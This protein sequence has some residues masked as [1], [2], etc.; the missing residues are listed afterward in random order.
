MGIVRLNELP[1]GSGSLTSDD[2]FIF[3]DDPSGGG[4]TKK[5]S[6]T[7][8]GNAIGG[9]GSGIN[10]QITTV[11]LHNGGVQTAQVL[12]F[13]D[14][15]YQS[16]ITGP[17]PASGNNAQRIIVQGSRGQGNG[18]G[19]DVYMWG[20]DS[21]ING[22]D[23]K[24]YAG[25]A[26]NAAPN[27]GYG[28]YVNIDGGGGATTGGNVEITAGYSEGGQAGDIYIVGGPTSSGVAG[29]VNIR[30]NN[31]TNNWTFSPNGS[32][33]LP[34]GNLI[35]S[36]AGQGETNI[37]I[38][39]NESPFKI[40]TSASTGAKEWRYD[41]NGNL[42]LPQGSILSETNNTVSLM[43]PTAV[44]GQSLVIRPTIAAWSITSSGYIVYD[45]PITIS[46]NQLGVGNYFGTVNYS[47]TGSGVSPQSLGRALTGNVVFSGTGPETET[48]TWTIPS[49]SNISEFTL[50]LTSVE[51]VDW[52][53]I[54]EHNDPALYYNFEENAMPSGQFVTV[55]NSGISNSEHSHIHL[56]AGDPSTVDIYLGDD[57]QYVKIEKNGGDV[58]IGT[59]NNNNHWTFGTDGRLTLPI[60]GDILDSNGTSVLPS[61]IANSGDN[62]ILTSTGTTTGINAESNATFDGS[63]LSVSGV[64]VATSG[65]FTQR[66]DAPLSYFTLSPAISGTV[67]NWNPGSVSDIIR[68]SGIENARINGL[69]NTYGADA[70]LLYN[71]GTSGNI[72]LTH[73]S[74]TANNQFLVPSLGDYVLGPNGGAALIVRDKVD[75]KWRVT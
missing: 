68:A 28:G 61:T 14:D 58:V 46:V 42:T 44:S 6:L 32:F 26:D 70:M 17:I 51:G 21:D 18:E 41:A 53:D 29:D 30:T 57:D 34:N 59:D 22:G 54:P 50:T 7:E 48:I 75:N 55:T 45:S 66:L 20:G 9:G 1:E 36:Q 73:A 49:N 74:G 5:I 56:I 8:I 71:V 37:Q 40:Y 63:T 23:I 69:V 12:K 19:G 15:S 25:D 67:N 33:T 16:V 39:D 10:F 4:T 38:V 43:P 65:S 35:Q 2:I 24:I 52:N 47:I 62:R 27:N 64:F 72:T 13:D 60:D 3:M 11:D 31:N